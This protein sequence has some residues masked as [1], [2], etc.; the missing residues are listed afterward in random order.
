[1]TKLD[2]LHQIEAREEQKKKKQKLDQDV[3]KFI[4]KEV[5]LTNLSNHTKCSFLTIEDFMV[6]THFENHVPHLTFDFMN[7]IS[8][9][10]IDLR[11]ISRQISGDHLLGKVE[12]GVKQR[13]SL[14]D[15]QVNA[16]VEEKKS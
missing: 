3:L 8:A 4:K 2:M 15:P 16:R 10:Q 7:F 14:L 13:L 11:D 6:M 9:N 1:M 5:N 12:I